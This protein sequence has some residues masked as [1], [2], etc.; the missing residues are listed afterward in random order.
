MQK[1]LV[2]IDGSAN[3]ERAVQYLVQLVNLLSDQT[4]IHLL[5]VQPAIHSGVVKMFVSQDSINKFHQEHGIEALRNACSILDQA[6][7]NYIRHIGVGEASEIIQQYAKEKKCA[8][9]IMGSRGMSSAAGLLLGS[10]AAKVLH[11]VDIPVTLVK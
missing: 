8:H 3:A 10:V 1:I 6:K 11:L 2:P 4:E 5:N 9:I 7:V